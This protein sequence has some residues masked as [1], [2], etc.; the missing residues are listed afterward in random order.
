MNA[1]LLD[2]LDVAVLLL[3]DVFKCNDVDMQAFII[4]DS[5]QDVGDKPGDAVKPAGRRSVELDEVELCARNRPQNLPPPPP[6]SGGRQG[7]LV[8][9]S[10]KATTVA[11]DIHP[12]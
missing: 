5:D 2:E 7:I 9:V 12:R 3:E 11:T 8:C 10:L 4:T 1:L 6:I